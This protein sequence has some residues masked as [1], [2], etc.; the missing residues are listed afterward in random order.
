MDKHYICKMY[1]THEDDDLY[2]AI[3]TLSDDLL[4]LLKNIMPLVEKLLIASDGKFTHL[5]ILDYK[6][7]FCIQP[8]S[9]IP[10]LF[11][12][13]E[14]FEEALYCGEIIQLPDDFKIPAD[15]AP[16]LDYATL[17][18]DEYGFSWNCRE[19]HSPCD[20]STPTFYFKDIGWPALAVSWKQQTT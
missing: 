2:L 4:D 5:E 9:G 12:K 10:S 7:T 14:E 15:N 18:V 8:P 11:E 20:Q 13:F 17:Q 6:P 3:V 1:S 16:K 19:K